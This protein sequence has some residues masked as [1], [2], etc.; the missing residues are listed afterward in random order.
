M[1]NRILESKDR[2][3]GIYGD[4][5]SNSRLHS[6]E[7]IVDYLQSRGLKIS[8]VDGDMDYGWE[9]N[10][11]GSPSKLFAAI[12]H[13]FKGYDCDSVEEF[14]DNY[15]IDTLDEKCI[16]ESLMSEGSEVSPK[17]LADHERI[18]DAGFSRQKVSQY[19]TIVGPEDMYYEFENDDI[20]VYL[21]IYEDSYNKFRIVISG[22]D[23]DRMIMNETP[24]TL[25]NAL[26]I[27]NLAKDYF[28]KYPASTKFLAKFA[29][30]YDLITN[31]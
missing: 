24:L 27:F 29:D 22:D 19:G 3:V 13:T 23:D 10:V 18:M 14:I 31:G 9:M 2:T 8:D 12:V 4:E 21:E 11:T 5:G 7:D 1:I 6:V 16:D 26:K 25:S 15:A 17:L 28:S 20:F 30:E